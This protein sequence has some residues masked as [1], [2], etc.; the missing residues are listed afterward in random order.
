M[1]NRRRILTSQSGGPIENIGN[2]EAWWNRD[3]IDPGATTQGNTV[4][5]WTDV[6]GS[7]V[8]TNTIG[9]PT[10]NLNG[11][12]R[13]VRFDG[14]SL[15]AINEWPAIDFVG[16]TDAFTLIAKLGE[17]ISSNGCMIGKQ[18]NGLD[19]VQYQLTAAVLSPGQVGHHVGSVSSTNSFFARGTRASGVLEPGAVLA[20]TVGTADNFDTVAYYNNE[21]LPYTL[22][23]SPINETIGTQVNNYQVT[24]GGRRNNSDVAGGFFFTGDIAHI[25]MYSKE[26]TPA[27]IAT[28]VANLN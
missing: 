11:G 14:A 25:L 27:E 24:V 16:R 1:F 17:T 20:V 5:T 12:L 21:Q 8:L 28:V 9:T 23:A 7:R 3:G 13:E 4:T 10:L 19:D 18:Q 6:V 26:L 2:L 15:L 22:Y